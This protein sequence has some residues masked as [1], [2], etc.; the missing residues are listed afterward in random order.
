[1]A[2]LVAD[3]I[4]AGFGFGTEIVKAFEAA[5]PN[6]NERL[7]A[8]AKAHSEA[9]AA[10]QASD[11]TQAT[12]MAAEAAQKGWF[13]KP[14]IAAAWICLGALVLDL[15]TSQGVW[16]S[17]ALGHPFPEP[18]KFLTEQLGT[19]LEGIFGLGSL[20]VAHQGYKQWI[21]SP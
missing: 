21:A 14:H 17:Y 12:I 8:M 5:Y 3:P 18:P 1:M 20:T 9:Q 11:T 6:P 10:A 13:N 19:L 15:L 16:L 7:A 4:S 2:E